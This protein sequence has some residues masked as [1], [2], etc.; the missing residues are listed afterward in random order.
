M[1]DIIELL[2][3][4]SYEYADTWSGLRGQP[5]FIPWTALPQSKRD[6]FSEHI[7]AQLRALHAAG[8]QIVPKEPTE[9]MCK[10]GDQHTH[11][12]GSC[13]NRTGRDTYRAMLA[14]APKP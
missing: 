10:A 3:R 8:L 13:G 12:G 2:A 1:T 5:P 11:C 4:A 9:E 6:L 14:A 7:G